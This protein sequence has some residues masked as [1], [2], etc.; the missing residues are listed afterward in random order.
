MSTFKLYTSAT[1]GT[2]FPG[3]ISVTENVDGSTGALDYVLYLGSI[4][5][6]KKLQAQNNPDGSAGTPGTTQIT[7]TI[8]NSGGGESSSAVK[9]AT[10]EAGLAAATA[11]AALNLGTTINSGVG[12]AAAIWLRITDQTNVVGTYTNLSI[13]TNLLVESNV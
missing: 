5:S 3:T 2:E 9:L 4:A 1:L 8:V 11:G 7:V 13:T 6:G 12:S 10:T